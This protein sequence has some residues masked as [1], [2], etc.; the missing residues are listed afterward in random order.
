MLEAQA[1]NLLTDREKRNFISLGP[2]YQYDI[3]ESIHI[4]KKESLVGDDGRPLMKDSRFETFKKKYDNYKKIYE[5]NIKYE[6]FANWYFEKKLLGYSYSHKL[7]DVFQ[8][9]HGAIKDS[10]HY[11]SMENN[12]RSKFVGVVE[13]S[14]RKTSANGNQ[15]I[16]VLLADEYGNMPAMMVDS[17]RKLSCTEYIESGKKVPEKDNIL[18]IVGRKANDILFI[19]SMSIVDER[20]YMKLADIK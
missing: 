11:H 9:E 13:D 1:F 14:F 3:L 15:Y 18:I 2:Q 8:D 16:K 6:S 7:K 12:E 10:L 5:Q 19:D 17:R 20:I 4:A